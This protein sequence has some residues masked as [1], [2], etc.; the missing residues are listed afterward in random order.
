MTL[1]GGDPVPV[2]IEFELLEQCRK[3]GIHTVVETS[4]YTDE[5]AFERILGRLTGCLLTQA[6]GLKST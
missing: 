6:Y 4:A 2:G 1:T 5:E 3:R